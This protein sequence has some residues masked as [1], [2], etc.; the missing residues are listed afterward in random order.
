MD[1]MDE[2]IT[3]N[4]AGEDKLCLRRVEGLQHLFVLRGCR[5][6]VGKALVR[7]QHSPDIPRGQRR[8]LPSWKKGILPGR[9]LSSSPEPEQGIVHTIKSWESG[10][11]EGF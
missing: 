9:G 2:K 11:S 8:A 7:P 1:G 3:G 4:R 10:D 5:S 6:Q